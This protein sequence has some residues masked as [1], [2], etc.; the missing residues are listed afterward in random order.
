MISYD[1]KWPL[2]RICIKD[3]YLQFNNWG[4]GSIEDTDWYKYPEDGKVFE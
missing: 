4:L 2:E 3:A 1:F